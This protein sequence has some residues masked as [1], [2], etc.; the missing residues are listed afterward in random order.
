MSKRDSAECA[1]LERLV[2]LKPGGIAD[3]GRLTFR[4]ESYMADVDGAREIH[5]WYSFDE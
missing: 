5:W 4:T 1:I 3:E 2:L